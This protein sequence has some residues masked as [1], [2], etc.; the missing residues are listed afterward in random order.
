M[1]ETNE[2][3]KKRD[4][5]GKF[6]CVFSKLTFDNFAG[7]LNF[8][9]LQYHLLCNAILF[10]NIS[11]FQCSVLEKRRRICAIWSL[12]LRVD[13]GMALNGAA[14]CVSVWMSYNNTDMRQTTICTKTF[15]AFP[16]FYSVH[17]ADTSAEAAAAAN[18]SNSFSHSFIYSLS[19]L[20][21]FVYSVFHIA[22]PHCHLHPQSPCEFFSFSPASATTMAVYAIVL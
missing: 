13:G 10:G 15:M 5:F 18:S 7:L 16:T 3:T 11:H 12:I 2:G 20:F 19:H 21:Y 8:H 4:F 9:L 1:V 6:N 17:T 22:Y 14:V